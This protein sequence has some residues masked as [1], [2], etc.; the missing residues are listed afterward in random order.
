VIKEKPISVLFICTGNSARSIMG[1]LAA[2][3][4]TEGKFIGYSAGS[5]PAEKI[6]DAALKIAE[7]IL[8]P[9]A[10]LASE[11][12]ELYSKNN[13]FFDF[14]ITVCDQARETCPVFHNSLNTFHWAYEDPALIID[15]EIRKQKLFSIYH[16]IGS[17]LNLLFKQEM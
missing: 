17:K 9:K 12:I 2:N 16:D 5:N 1:E 15:F 14:T 4:L 11:S 7:E 10:R 8:Y 13:F 6:N 3:T